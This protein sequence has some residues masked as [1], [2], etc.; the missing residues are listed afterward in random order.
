[1]DSSNN[2]RKLAWTVPEKE[3]L[4]NAVRDNGTPI[5]TNKGKLLGHYNGY[6]SIAHNGKC[7]GS[8]CI[9]LNK[10]NEQ[11]WLKGSTYKF[12]DGYKLI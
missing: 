8:I 5:Y 2:K 6:S 10:S 12:N 7:C 11:M 3:N 9:T 4:Y 1:M